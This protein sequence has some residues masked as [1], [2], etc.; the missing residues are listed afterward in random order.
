VLVVLVV[1]AAAAAVVVCKVV[2]CE[3]RARFAGF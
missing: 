3:L 1:L 2:M